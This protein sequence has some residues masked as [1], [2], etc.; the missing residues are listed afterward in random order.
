MQDNAPLTDEE[1][2]RWIAEHPDHGPLATVITYSDDE[3][4]F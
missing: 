2:E 4:P 1:L 3:I